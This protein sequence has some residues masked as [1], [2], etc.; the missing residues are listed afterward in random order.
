MNS[1]TPQKTISLPKTGHTV[2]LKEWLTV[3]EERQ[4]IRAAMAMGDHESESGAAKH[5][6]FVEF[7][8]TE[9]E[10]CVVSLNG[11]SENIW[12]RLEEY[13][14]QDFKALTDAIKEVRG[15]SE[16]KKSE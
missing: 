5:D 1:E 13:P 12:T 15:E 8:K 14:A 10:V 16:E 2:I 9:I 7:Q 6:A 3:K 11:N 4:I